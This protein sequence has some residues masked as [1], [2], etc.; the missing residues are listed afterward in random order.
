M[1]DN[2]LDA[3]PTPSTSTSTASIELK[4]YLATPVDPSV[5]DALKWWYNHH[6]EYPRLSR[7]A[8]DYLSI[9]PTSVDVEHVFSRG[10]ILLSY[11]RNRMSA[12]TTRSL[13][14]LNLWLK[15]GIV[16]TSTVVAAICQTPDVEVVDID[17][18]AAEGGLGA[19]DLD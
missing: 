5:R 15:A 19:M 10:C 3:A 18:I 16:K 7:M 11:L 14:C 4:T 8:R 6:F 12:E 13:M 17:N 2:L 9:P 1:F